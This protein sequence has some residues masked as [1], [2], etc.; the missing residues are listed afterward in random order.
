MLSLYFCSLSFSCVLLAVQ[1]RD[2]FFNLRDKVDPSDNIA[3]KYV[4]LDKSAGSACSVLVQESGTPS[5]SLSIYPSLNS[6]SLSL[7]S[8]SPLSELS[9]LSLSWSL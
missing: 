5:Y 9:E 2:V 7:N 8:L 6:L 3:A 1:L 4:I